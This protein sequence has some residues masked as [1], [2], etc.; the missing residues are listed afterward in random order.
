M[1]QR[2]PMASPIASTPFEEA[3]ERLTRAETAIE[4]QRGQS[5]ERDQELPA[6]R[7]EAQQLRTQV[8]NMSATR[9]T[10]P[11]NNNKSRIPLGIIGGIMA[12]FS[13]SK[14]LSSSSYSVE[15][16][17]SYI[18]TG[19][20]INLLAISGGIGLVILAFSSS[21]NPNLSERDRKYAEMPASVSEK[22]SALETRI[23]NI[24]Q[25]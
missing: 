10:A 5:A 6:L 14:L 7:A 16:S 21:K 1:K 17:R 22:L 2:D 11:G 4:R 24:T 15:F 18:I 12:I 9:D 8:M 20:I 19:V 23:S 13:L 25:P 3:L